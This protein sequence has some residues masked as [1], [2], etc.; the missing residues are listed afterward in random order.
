MSDC[1]ERLHP[2]SS[3]V[4]DGRH[5][6]EPR[7]VAKGRRSQ[8]EQDPARK[9]RSAGPACNDHHGNGDERDCDR[10]VSQPMPLVKDP[11]GRLA[12]LAPMRDPH[13]GG[14]QRRAEHRERDA[15][16]A[17]TGARFRGHGGEVDA[18][19]KGD[20]RGD[21]Q[22]IG[23]RL[24]AGIDRAVDP[25]HRAVNVDGL[26]SLLGAI[27]AQ[28]DAIRRL[29]FVSS[30]FVYNHFLSKRAQKNDPTQPINMYN[31]TKLAG[32]ILTRN[33]KPSKEAHKV[34]SKMPFP[35]LSVADDSY[36]VASKVHDLTVKIRPDDTKKIALIRDLI[37]RHVD[38]NK[39]LAAL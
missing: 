38:A 18:R 15:P 34:I 6:G 30:S 17:D 9:E 24:G 21:D 10:L 28:R 13:R 26:L 19:R 14:H 8:C 29:V 35:V 11:G 16:H 7:P 36:Y 31:A 27:G 20:D 12:V 5:A 32:M 2:V 39:I 4:L 25:P 37:A 22:E 1:R 23:A 3:H 33:L